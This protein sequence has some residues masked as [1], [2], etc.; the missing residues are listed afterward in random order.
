MKLQLPELKE[1]VNARSDENFN[2]NFTP[3]LYL[4][5]HLCYD[6]KKLPLNR[7]RIRDDWQ[8]YNASADLLVGLAADQEHKKI[9]NNHRDR[10]KKIVEA[11]P[12][13]EIANVEA[14]Q[15][16]MSL[17]LEVNKLTKILLG[18]VL[19]EKPDNLSLNQCSSIIATLSEEIKQS[20]NLKQWSELVKVERSTIFKTFTT[21]ELLLELAKYQ[22]SGAALPADIKAC[23]NTLRAAL[24]DIE[25]KCEVLAREVSIYSSMRFTSPDGEL[26]EL[27]KGKKIVRAAELELDMAH[28]RVEDAVNQ[29]KESIA[30]NQELLAT[31]A[32]VLTQSYTKMPTV[33]V[34][35]F[36]KLRNPSD[37]EQQVEEKRHL[38]AIE[39]EKQM[40]Q[41]ARLWEDHT[42]LIK[43]KQAKDAQ[44]QP[45]G[46]GFFDN[47]PQKALAKSSAAPKPR[48]INDP[49][50]VAMQAPVV[51]GVVD[52]GKGKEELD[53]YQSNLK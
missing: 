13:D 38:R 53:E 17:A 51:R 23:L 12:Q 39:R 7:E 3:Y 35:Q 31:P 32:P 6:L 4:T 19:S 14:H 26:P 8:K 16:L 33:N 43:D 5:Q 10:L 49:A 46:I 1:L 40:Q 18:E 44:E 47:N 52:N 37:G 36:S 9:I 24:K 42:Q 11:C 2:E 27:T 34:Q 29:L 41:F 22:V 25:D 30:I 28:Y 50:S 20:Y 21:P 15:K 48:V 45:R